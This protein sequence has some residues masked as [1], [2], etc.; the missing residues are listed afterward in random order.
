MIPAPMSIA[1]A[2]LSAAINFGDAPP[3]TLQDHDYWFVAGYSTMAYYVD[4]ATIVS[5][6]NVMRAWIWF[7]E[8]DRAPAPWGGSSTRTLD[9]VNCRTHQARTLQLM[10][11][12]SQGTTMVS[13]QQPGEWSYEAP[14]SVGGAEIEFICSDATT[15]AATAVQL[16][17]IVTP[18]RHARELFDLLNAKHPL[19][20]DPPGVESDANSPP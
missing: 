5:N 19:A 13:D 6:D 1:A 8:S 15:R 14:A 12:D 18:E 2:T 11:Y 9:E 10:V 3:V 4:A 7:F 17:Q 20:S 16:P